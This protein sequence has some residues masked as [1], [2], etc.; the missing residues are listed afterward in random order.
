MSA[1]AAE[2]AAAEPAAAKP[3][4]AKPIAAEPVAEGLETVVAKPARGRRKILLWAEFLL[5]FV[6]IPLLLAFGLSPRVM[7]TLLAGSF[8]LGLGLLALTPGVKLG[9]LARGPLVGSWRGLLG[10]VALTGGTVY[11]LT[12][13]LLPGALWWMPTRMPDLWIMIMAFYPLLSA[14][15]QE[16]VFRVLF[17]RRYGDLF[18]S[19]AV[20]V[21][22]N[23][24]V[25]ALAH[26]FLWNWVALALTFAGG[27]LFSWAYLGGRGRNFW[28][29][30]LLHAIA[31]WLIFTIGL[32][33]FF[34]HGAVPG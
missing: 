6:G 34:Y 22:V 14:L 23:G 29:P 33:R 19:R 7:W 27:V 8:V 17:F 31:G 1:G 4:A 26:L 30:V 5:L 3:A 16:A 25:F 9:E 18:A 28:Y 10:F 24:A 13:S 20:A 11:L 15:P 21:A 32:G 2:P 12:W